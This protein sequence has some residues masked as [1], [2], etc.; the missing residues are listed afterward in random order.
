MKTLKEV[1]EDVSE[2]ANQLQ[3]DWFNVS[4]E[5]GKD[6]DYQDKLNVWLFVK[7]AQQE[8]EIEKLKEMANS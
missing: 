5:L 4:E 8:I 1:P 6:I 7:I 2:R 3:K